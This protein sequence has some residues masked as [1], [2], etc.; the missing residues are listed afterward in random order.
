[1]KKLIALV[2]AL[3]LLIGLAAAPAAADGKPLKILIV[4]S[5]GVDDGNFNQDCYLGITNF[6]ANHGDCT[7][8]D[9]KEP[10]MAELIPTIEKLVGDY[11]VF[12]CPGFNFGAIGDIVTANP[13][14]YFLV[15]DSTIVDSEGTPVSA[16]NVYTMMYKE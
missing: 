8:Q 10:D 1:M 11:D 7:V 14:K 4:T 6:I 12:V 2:C 13:D 15:V 5:S 16:D 9:I 3:A